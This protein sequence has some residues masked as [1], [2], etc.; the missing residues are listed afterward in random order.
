MILYEMLVGYPPFASETPQE[1]YSKILKWRTC[2]EFP[3]DIAISEP[4]KAV[5]LR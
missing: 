5:I 2:L 3:A 1:T 4:G